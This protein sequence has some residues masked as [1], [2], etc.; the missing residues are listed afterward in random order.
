MLTLSGFIENQ[1]NDVQI[2]GSPDQSVPDSDSDKVMP[3]PSGSLQVTHVSQSPSRD[4]V[5]TSVS[6][7]VGSSSSLVVTCRS[8]QSKALATG[9]SGDPFTPIDPIPSTIAQDLQVVTGKF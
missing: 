8:S 4:V 3:Q 1:N 9:S 5:S 6:K 7:S 2:R